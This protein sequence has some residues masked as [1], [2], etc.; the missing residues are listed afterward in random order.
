M[1]IFRVRIKT[2]RRISTETARTADHRVRFFTVGFYSFGPA[3]YFAS[4][5]RGNN[6]IDNSFAD[7]LLRVNGTRRSSW[8]TSVL[9][10]TRVRNRDYVVLT[11]WMLRDANCLGVRALFRISPT[12]RICRFTF[13]PCEYESRSKMFASCSVL[14]TF[15]SYIPY[16]VRR[17]TFS[18]FPEQF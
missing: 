14:L 17:F 9:V 3:V 11:E 10:K 5:S 4:I 16:L 13:A 1:A 8:L 7:I 12:V 6:R 2:R 15:R 18:T